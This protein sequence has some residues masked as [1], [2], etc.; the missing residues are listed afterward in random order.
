MEFTDANFVMKQDIRHPDV[1]MIP[2]RPT[3]FLE[4][5]KK[6]NGIEWIR[7]TAKCRRIPERTGVYSFEQRRCFY[8]F[9]VR[10]ISSVFE[11]KL[12][13]MP[14]VGD[15]PGEHADFRRVGGV[16]QVKEPEIQRS[17]RGQVPLV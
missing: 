13:R 1:N 17:S 7:T 8:L 4:G 14:A 15:L 12:Q 2:R 16:R 3:S 11:R 9:R 10:R 6:K 5:F